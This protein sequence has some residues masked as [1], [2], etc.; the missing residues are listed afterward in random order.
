MTLLSIQ[1]ERVAPYSVLLAAPLALAFVA[2][3]PLRAGRA[4]LAL[5]GGGTGEVILG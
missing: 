5:V 2:D 1:K 4:M 3:T